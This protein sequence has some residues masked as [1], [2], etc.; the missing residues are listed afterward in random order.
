MLTCAETYRVVDVLPTRE[1]GPLTRWLL[2]HPGVDV[3]CRDRAGALRRGRHR[4]APNARQ[5]ADRYHLWVKV[6]DPHSSQ[7]PQLP[8]HS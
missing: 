8:R 5:V 6:V 2:A 4:P 3:I 1:A 7:A